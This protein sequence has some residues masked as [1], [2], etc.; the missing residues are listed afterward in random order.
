MEFSTCPTLRRRTNTF[1]V[2]SK[3]HGDLDLPETFDVVSPFHTSL[4]VRH[5][6]TGIYHNTSC[7]LFNAL[8]PFPI[9]A[10]HK[11]NILLPLQNYGLLV[12][13]KQGL[14]QSQFHQYAYWLR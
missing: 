3:M 7:G 14:T 6:Q 1:G 9:L 4:L 8:Y 11:K 12:T 2:I 13:L 5:I 10:Q